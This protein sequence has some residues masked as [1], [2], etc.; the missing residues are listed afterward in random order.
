MALNAI[1]SVS[2]SHHIATIVFHRVAQDAWAS[3]ISAWPRIKRCLPQ[4]CQIKN[5]MPPRTGKIRVKT[6]WATRLLPRCTHCRYT[7]LTG[8][9]YELVEV[10]MQVTSTIYKK[11]KDDYHHNDQCKKRYCAKRL[12]LLPHTQLAPTRIVIAVNR[13]TNYKNLRSNAKNSFS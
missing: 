2:T 4:S 12:L 9:V 10:D 5:L 1:T 13:V 11:D 7:N 3:V 8:L 6:K